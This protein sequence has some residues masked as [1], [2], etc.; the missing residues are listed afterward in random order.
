MRMSQIWH[1]NLQ[2]C[3]H[4]S[5]GEH[6]ALQSS[7]KL[8][9]SQFCLSVLLK[10][11]KIGNGWK[12]FNTRTIESSPASRS[13]FLHTTWLRF[14]FFAYI[15]SGSS[16]HSISGA[17]DVSTRLRAIPLRTAMNKG[18]M[19]CDFSLVRNLV[20]NTIF[21]SAGSHQTHHNEHR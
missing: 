6:K 8:C 16:G 5:T 3:R 9:V 10:H 1:N 13:T 11:S 12:S 17:V 20:H 4:T 15:V 21:T 18:F 2:I 19:I 7:A 14:F